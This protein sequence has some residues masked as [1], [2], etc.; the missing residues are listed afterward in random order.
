MVWQ[1]KL[2]SRLYNV[3]YVHST[4]TLPASLRNL[5]KR[6]PRIIYGML[7]KSA[8]SCI[9]KIGGKLQAKLGM[10]GVLHTWGSDL[11]YHPH[12]HCLITF[13]GLDKNHEWVWP[14]SSRRL[15]RYKKINKYYKE[16]FLK[17]LEQGF[18][19]GAI[20]YHLNYEEICSD[21]SRSNWVVNND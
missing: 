12:I 6:N 15:A 7:F 4:F 2:S 9:K 1:S 21:I 19:S 20:K 18:K 14:E 13:G 3:P 11:K 8:W 10:V 17:N 5:A 16:S